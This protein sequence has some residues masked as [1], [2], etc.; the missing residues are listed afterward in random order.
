MVLADQL[1]VREAWISEH[2][3]LV[4]FQAPDQLPSA[5][6]FICKAAALTQQ[7]RPAGHLGAAL[8]SSPAGGDRRGGV[9]PPDRRPGL[10][11]VWRGPRRREHAPARPAPGA[12]AGDGSGG[13]RPHPHGLDGAGALRLGWRVL[14]RRAVAHHP[15]A[16]HQAVHGRGH[17]LRAQR[18]NAGAHGAKGLHAVD[19]LD[20]HADPVARDDRD[21][22]GGWRRG[23]GCRDPA[24]GA[25]RARRPR[26]RFRRGSEATASRRGPR[27]RA[28]GRPARPVPAAGLHTGRPHHGV[29]DR[30]GGLHLRGT[31]TR[32]TIASST[33]TTVSAGSAC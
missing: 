25:D 18:R 31:R 22:S 1:G 12:A 7:I 17:R 33:S 21:L 6:L 28:H 14:A 29:S 11:G 10:C 16:A 20:G 4:S 24:A 8:L 23:P 19:D 27:R 2:G 30:P 5:D 32:C 9:R 15:A 13:H 26:G 3:T